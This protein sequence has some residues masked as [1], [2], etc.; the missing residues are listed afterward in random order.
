MR[1]QE[2]VAYTMYIVNVDLLIYFL[3]EIYLYL[4]V[5]LQVF[6]NSYLK[7]KGICIFYSKQMSV[8]NTVLL[9]LSLT[10]I[11]LL[12]RVHTSITILC[13]TYFQ[14]VNLTS[15]LS[16]KIGC[17]A[18]PSTPLNNFFHLHI[19]YENRRC[20]FNNMLTIIEFYLQPTIELQFFFRIL[21]LLRKEGLFEYI[22]YAF[23]KIKFK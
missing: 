7:L 10:L 15:I 18:L 19:Y 20:V 4:K 2:G 9:I 12:R 1:L 17:V 22:D 5:L 23:Y 6:F 11:Y 14:N 16:N 3:L 21:E 13:M 8:R